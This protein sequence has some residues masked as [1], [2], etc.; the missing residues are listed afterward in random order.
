MQTD[1]LTA[2]FHFMLRM[3]IS[4]TVLPADALFRETPVIPVEAEAEDISEEQQSVPAVFPERAE[5]SNSA[6]PYVSKNCCHSDDSSLFSITT[7]AA[8]MSGHKKANRFIRLFFDLFPIVHRQLFHFVV[9]RNVIGGPDKIVRQ[10][11]L[12]YP[13]LWEVM[14]IEIILPFVLNFSRIRMYVL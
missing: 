6:I 4:C 11:L 3:N 9:A 10:I 2:D 12:L 5:S 1:T 14:R 8:H 7:V 13:V